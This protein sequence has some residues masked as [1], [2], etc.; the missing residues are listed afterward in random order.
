MTIAG[1]SPSSAWLSAQVFL[2]RQDVKL[3]QW[4]EK[5][6]HRNNLRANR[7]VVGSENV[8]VSMTTHGKRIETV[9]LAI[10]SIASG[11]SLPARLILWLD[12]PRL[13]GNLPDSLR[14]L[15]SR[16]LEIRLTENFGP[17]TKYYPYLLNAEFLNLPLVIADDDVMYSPWWLTGLARA[18]RHNPAV[19]NCYRAHVIQV[20]D[21]VIQPYRTWTRCASSVADYRHFATGV[22]GCIYPPALLQKVKA[23]GSAFMR[24]CPKADDIWLH[25]NAL[26]NGFRIRQILRRQLN[27]PGV[28]DTQETALFLTN[29]VS[30]NDEQARNTYTSEDIA[31]LS[32]SAATVARGRNLACQEIAGLKSEG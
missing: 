13:F 26:R 21:G 19:V 12:D 5:S 31:Q 4:R 2:A 18:W 22:S 24:S 10:E 14:R 1:S 11:D 15:E 28:R 3:G 17:H 27:F 9:Y 8:H 30:G 16:G 32:A 6:L 29:T 20:Q 25:V 23:E 7:L